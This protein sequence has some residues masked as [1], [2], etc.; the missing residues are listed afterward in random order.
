MA[1]V[2]KEVYL[3]VSIRVQ[4][5]VLLFVFFTLDRLKRTVILTSSW[6]KNKHQGVDF[7]L[8]A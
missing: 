2:R 7:G 5:Y 6:K 8:N 1:V 3:Y 4:D